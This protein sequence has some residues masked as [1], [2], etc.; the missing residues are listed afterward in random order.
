MARLRYIN[1][2]VIDELALLVTKSRSVS[3]PKRPRDAFDIYL[4]VA[5]AR[6]PKALLTSTRRLKGETPEAFL[7]LAS[8]WSVLHDRGAAFDR[9]VNAYLPK[10]RRLGDV[11]LTGLRP[12]STRVGEFLSQS[13]V[14]EVR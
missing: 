7:S 5:Q 2:P 12:F 10:T 14:P 1:I 3:S 9:R 8:I 6:D 11:E 4:A 13:G